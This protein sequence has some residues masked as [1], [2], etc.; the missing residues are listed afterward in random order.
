M[1][2]KIDFAVVILNYNSTKLT[3]K[4]VDSLL[5]YE[6]SNYLIFI[7]DNNSN[8]QNKLDL[9]KIDN[10]KIKKIYLSKNLG[11]ANGNN[12]I[13]KRILDN[14]EP[15]YIVIMNPDIEIIQNNTIANIINLIESDNR[16]VGGQPLVWNYRY[17]S[18]P[19]VQINISKILSFASLL[20]NTSI[21][22]RLV[23][24]KKHKKALYM[25]LMPYDR[26][27]PYEVP[28]GAFF[29]IRTDIF[30]QV[31]FFDNGTF[32]YYEELILGRKIAQLGKKFILCSQ[33]VVKHD[34]G[35]TTNS[36]RYSF[37]Y[38][39]HKIRMESSVYYAKKYLGANLFKVFLLKTLMYTDVLVR[40][41][42]SNIYAFKK[43]HFLFLMMLLFDFS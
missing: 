35:A 4:A 30:E 10:D 43:K 39:M 6:E 38:N 14:Y 34:H 21:L 17:G 11:Y 26:D 40:Y 37:N 27:I 5:K 3:K 2:R 22:L 25:D 12:E 20:I 8:C 24:S 31:D 1:A 13:I 36:N 15:K 29:L 42:A 9:N 41:A 32:L 7:G 28:S 23:F 16:Y 33:Y 18:S 19:N